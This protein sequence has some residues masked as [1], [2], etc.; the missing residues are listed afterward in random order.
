MASPKA[1]LGA[2]LVAALL[3]AQ[4]LP[5]APPRAA[6]SACSPAGDSSGDCCPMPHPIGPADPVQAAPGAPDCCAISS[7]QPG[8]SAATTKGVEATRVPAPAPAVSAEP[9]VE[10]A[11]LAPRAGGPPP[12]PGSS[13]H[14]LYCVFLI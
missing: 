13:L 3:L 1:K 5:G 9:D 10:G 8:S 2:F 14:T 12:R 6:L 11:A 7:S 4:P